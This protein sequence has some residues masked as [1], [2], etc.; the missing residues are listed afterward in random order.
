MPPHRPEPL[1]LRHS[2]NPI[3]TAAQWPYPVHSVFNPGAVRLPNGSTLLLCRVEDHRGLSHL[4]AARSANGIDHWDIDA[5]PTLLPAED[6]PEEAWG[7]EDPRIT[8]VP[9][10]ERYIIAYTC[11]SRA[12]PGVSLAATT[13]FVQFERYGTVMMPENKDAALFP[14]RV[15]GLWALVHRPVSPLGA[16]VWMAYSPDLRHWGGHHLVLHARRGA[17]WDAN[18]IGLSSPPLETPEGW[19]MIYHGVR[20][21]AAGCIYRVG[22]ALFDRQQ[23]ERCLRR[24]DTWVLGP[25]MPYECHGDVGNVVFPCGLTVAPDGDTLNLYYGAADSCVALATASLGALL[26]WLLQHNEEPRP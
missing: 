6:R 16:H 20:Q 15:Q 4:C 7:I 8:Y 13:D 3:L 26:A 19:L 2:H 5:A 21:T 12:G 22:L 24:G 14:T 17:W 25:E 11:Y 23:P 1:F 18:K 9:E 10:L